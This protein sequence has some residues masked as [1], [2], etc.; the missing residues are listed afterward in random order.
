MS[1]EQLPSIVHQVVGYIVAGLVSVVLWFE[2]QSRND[3][4]EVKAMVQ[5]DHTEIAVQ[6][7]EVSALKTSIADLNRVK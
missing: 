5:Q 2:V 1:K 6:K 3:F 4:K 7:A